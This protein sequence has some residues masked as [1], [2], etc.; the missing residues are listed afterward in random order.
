MYIA[1]CWALAWLYLMFVLGALAAT[2]WQVRHFAPEN[3]SESKSF[4]QFY[5]VTL[6]TLLA[7]VRLIYFA[8]RKRFHPCRAQ[9]AHPDRYD[10][11]PILCD[12][13]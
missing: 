5:T 9:T 11:D 2:D 13:Q 3:G 4:L 8:Y 6:S 1:D 7:F 10:C 12:P